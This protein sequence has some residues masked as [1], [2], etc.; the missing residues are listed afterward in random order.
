MQNYKK[1]IAAIVGVLLMLA[2][3]HW[4]IA[5]AVGFD[6]MVTNV[7]VGALTSVGVFGL[8]NTPP[9]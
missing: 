9:A 2:N 1:L 6:V 8:A 3:Q 7:I 5:I 4:G